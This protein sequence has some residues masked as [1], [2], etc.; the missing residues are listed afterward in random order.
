MAEA[1]LPR[2]ARGATWLDRPL[3]PSRERLS[4]LLAHRELLAYGTIALIG[5]LLRVWDVGSRA[6]H[7]DE[8]LHAYYA[9]QFFVGKGYSYLPLMHG[10]L[11]FVVVP[12]FYLVFGDSETSARLLAVVLGTVLI[13]LPYFLRQYLT[14]PGAMLTA[15]MIAIS[16]S[17]VYYSRFI[18]D[19]IYLACFT[20]ILFICVVRYLERHQARY[21]YIGATAMALAM[22][23]MEAAYLNFFIFG[24][25]LVFQII[26]EAMSRRS[27]PTPV[28]SAVRATSLDTWITGL[29]IFIVII[30]LLFSTFFT[31]PDG[32]WDRNHPLIQSGKW[33]TDRVDILGG[34]AYWLAQ[35]SVQRGGQP[36]FYYLLVLPLYEQLAVLFGL[37]GIAVAAIR[38]SLVTTFL[39]WWAVGSLVLYSWAGEKMPWLSIHVTL[40]FILLA[41]LAAGHVVRSRKGWVLPVA[42]AVF[43]ALFALEVHS[44][45][46][47]NYEDGANPTEMLIYVQTSQDVPNT[48]NAISTLSHQRFGG[49]SMPIGIDNSDVG[50]WPFQWYLRDYPNLF[51]T[52]AF[53]SPACGTQW[54]PVLLMLQPEYD[55]YA[56]TLGKHYV[57]QRYRWNWWFPEDYK[58]WFPDHVGTI[59]SALFGGGK[60]AS[61]PLGTPQDWHNLWNWLIYR[62]PFGD[63]GARML[64]FLVRRD[65]VPGSKYYSTAP[66]SSTGPVTA[67]AATVESVPS[68]AA[69][70]TGSYGAGSVTGPRGIAADRHG[71]LYVA[72]PAGHRVVELAPSGR[73]LRS[74]GSVGTGIG[75][76]NKL[77]SPQGVA[78][79]GDG[80]IYVTDTWNERVE[81]FSPTG[82]FLRQWGGG[83]IGS[84]PGQFYGPRSIAVGPK[85]QVFVADTGNERIQEFTPTGRLVTTWGGMGTSPGQF[86]EPSSVAVGPSG[87]VYVADFWNQ[88]IQVFTPSGTFLRSWPVADWT[89]HSYDEPYI[90]VSQSTGD[91]YASDP[92]QQRV[93]VW[94]PTGRLLG[95]IGKARVTLP[96]GVAIRSDGALAVSDSTA[97][98]V[99][100]FSVR[101]TSARSRS[102]R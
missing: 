20:L 12:I 24:S 6:M 90:A 21:V 15:L 98:R 66:P 92:Q 77:D 46:A 17:L 94:S 23:S 19:D 39:V 11:Q 81:V 61:A 45:F 26:R 40:P 96:L 41:G 54:C 35:H 28:L 22:A 64:Y 63:R 76:F 3:L 32:I 84:Q 102:H 65:L 25:F 8:S 52:T 100:L 97:A 95:A 50:G 4:A 72:D 43:A 18:R 34:I 56:A 99:D 49:T 27:D 93:L 44:T 86:T 36:W 101:L 37:A 31:N 38:R 16:P 57:V 82:R 47:L 85:G 58:Q 7:H 79:S 71:D 2:G 88:R 74:W 60:L 10:P 69:R 83:P 55:Q 67:P 29:A 9:W 13:G 73:V 42:G 1:T 14:R 68:L 75:Q 78:V 5:F 53:G 91:V 33:A 87:R 59:S 62:R 48:V 89:A 30:V 70:L 51:Y 80:N